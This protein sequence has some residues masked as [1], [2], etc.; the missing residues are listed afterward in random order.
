M[1]NIY[2][3]SLKKYIK[4]AKEQAEG[5]HRIAVD[6]ICREDKLNTKIYCNIRGLFY[7]ALQHKELSSENIEEI[8]KQ[9]KTTFKILNQFVSAYDNVVE[10]LRTHGSRDITIGYLREIRLNKKVKEGLD[11]RVSQ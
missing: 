3:N 1:E 9:N 5:V 8:I 10:D 2:V 11:K 6:K 4:Y 7:F